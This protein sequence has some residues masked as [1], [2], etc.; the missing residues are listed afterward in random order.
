MKPLLYRLSA[1]AVDFGALAI[2]TT[3]YVKSIANTRDLSDRMK[4]YVVDLRE[5]APKDSGLHESWLTPYLGR[6][7][8]K[9]E[10]QWHTFRDS[11]PLLVAVALAFLA[12]SRAVRY[13]GSGLAPAAAVRRRGI[14]YTVAGLAFVGFLHE[15]G[16]IFVLLLAGLNFALLRLVPRRW[17]P[18][19]VWAWHLSV[20]VANQYFDGYASVQQ[21]LGMDRFKG[22]TPWH[23]HF[24]LV[25]LRMISFDMDYLWAAAARGDGGAQSSWAELG[26][27]EGDGA[28]PRAEAKARARLPQAPWVYRDGFLYL[29]YLLYAPLYLAGPSMGFNDFASHLFLPQR[30]YDRRG[31]AKY[32]VRFF[33]VML[34]FEVFNHYFYVGALTESA[35][36]SP[37]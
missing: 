22:E 36:Q 34:F 31:L 6:L 13:R 7:L 19:A 18:V 26:S 20:L 9:K 4:A 23:F 1:A 32:T 17:G 28:D 37:Q 21:A 29:G 24:N 5:Q 25:V 2:A 12:A 8:D 11:L 10:S 15:S 14:F 35:R 30:S 3:Y 33:A 27:D 16:L